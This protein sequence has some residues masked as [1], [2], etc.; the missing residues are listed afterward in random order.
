ME[1]YL[2]VTRIIMF[3]QSEFNEEQNVRSRYVMS[4]KAN[5]HE[6]GFLTSPAG[7]RILQC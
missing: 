3:N 5:G 6:V 1:W 2:R 4:P 7:R